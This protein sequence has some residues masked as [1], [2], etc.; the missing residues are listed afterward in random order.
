MRNLGVF[1]LLTIFSLAA[2]AQTTS[3]RSFQWYDLV[4]NPNM[5]KPQATQSMITSLL[6]NIT[7]VGYQ[8]PGELKIDIEAER[9]RL[10][11]Y[12]TFMTMSFA[13]KQDIN[14][15]GVA[16]TG[17]AEELNDCKMDL[18]LELLPD[19]TGAWW[20]G[21]KAANCKKSEIK[22]QWKLED[23]VLQAKHVMVLYVKLDDIETNT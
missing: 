16:S 20:Q 1:I 7:P 22:F 14:K 2:S 18:Q 19:N 3:F 8:Y 23:V 4:S 15:D 9:V 13:R 12:Y 10:P 6:K 5:D 17:Y 11:G 21:N